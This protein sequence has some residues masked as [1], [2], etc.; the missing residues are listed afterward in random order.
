MIDSKKWCVELGNTGNKLQHSGVVF[1]TRS[2]G[3]FK[4]LFKNIH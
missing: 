3:I 4:Q 2:L 1:E